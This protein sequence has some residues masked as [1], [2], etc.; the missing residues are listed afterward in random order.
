MKGARRWFVPV[1]AAFLAAAL[2]AEG[3]RF[4]TASREHVHAA[5]SLAAVREDAGA[6]HRLRAL[7]ATSSL[8]E[9][10]Q[11]DVIA[12]VNEVMATA[13]VPACHFAG[14]QPEGEGRRLP[15]AE[16]L[17]QQTVRLTLNDV[18]LPDLGE[19]LAGLVTAQSLWTPTSLELVHTRQKDGPQDVYDVQ[20]VLAALYH[21][22]GE[23][24]R[25]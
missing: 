18:A 4:L 15:G 5:A 17:F 24:D 11:N 14:L 19:F 9:K 3:R 13:G 10:P 25:S 1:V 7:R 20:V 23:E 8:Q 16:A 2:L 12:L 21:A 6:V 22:G